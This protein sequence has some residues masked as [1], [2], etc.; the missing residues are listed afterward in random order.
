MTACFGVGVTRAL[1]R[2]ARRLCIG[3]D[4]LFPSPKEVKNPALNA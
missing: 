4:L 3:I 2:W 1:R